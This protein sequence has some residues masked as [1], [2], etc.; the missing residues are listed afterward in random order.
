MIAAIQPAPVFIGMKRH[1]RLHKLFAVLTSILMLVQPIIPIFPLITPQIFAQEVTPTPEPTTNPDPTPTEEQA[2]PTPTEEASPTP[3]EEISPTP[4]EEITPTPTLEIMPSVTPEASPSPEPT[5]EVTPTPSEQTNPPQQQNGEPPHETSP[6]QEQGQ[7]LDGASTEAT[8]T[9]TVTVEEPVEEGEL[10]AVVLENVEADSLNLDSVDP[11]NSATLT[12]DKADY[13]PTDTA[14]IS[15]TGFKANHT[16]NLTVKSDDAPIT[17]TTVEITTDENGSFVYAYQL[18]GIYRPNYQ[19]AVTNPGGHIIATTTFTD[20]N[21][22]ADLDQYANDD[23]DWVNGNLG[24][25]NSTYYE[26]DTVPYRMKFDNLSLASHTI[27]IEWDTAKSDKH[28]TDYLESYDATESPDPCDGVSGC[29]GPGTTFPIPKDPQ[30]DNG[31]GS[32]ITQ[33]AGNFTLFGGT[34][35]GVSAY[36][37]P[38]GAGF[39]EDKSAQITITFTATQANPVLSWGGHISDRA[40]WGTGNSAVAIP[41][42]PYHMRNEG[43]DGG[44]GNQDRSLSADAVIFP[45]SITIIKQATPEGSTSFSFT[46]SPSPLSNFSLVDDGTSANTQLFSN[47]VNFQDYTVTETVPGAWTL[48]TIECSVTSA[49]GGS[50][51]VTN[52]SV[53]I[54][55]KEGENVNCTFTNEQQA[56]HLIVIKHVINDDGGS[57]AASDFTMTINGVTATGGNSF[58]GE[59]SPGTDKVVTP[60]SYNI[61]ETGPTGYSAG[62]STDCTGTI[63]AGQT[64]TCTVTND[65][66]QAYITVT[67]VVTNDDG[68]SAAPDD[69]DLTLEGTPVISGIAVAVN[70]GTYTAGE[71]LLPGYIFE[72]FS[73]DCD[74]NEDVTVALGESKSCTLTNNDQQAYII[75]DKTVINDNGGSAVANDFLL[76]VDGTPVSD[77]VAYP[78]DPGAHTAGETPLPGYTAGA[79]GGDCDL[80]AGVTVAL[81]Q[82]KTCTITNDDVAPTVTLT[83]VVIK[84]NGGTA[85]VNDFG[86]TVGGSPVSSGQTVSVNANT[87]IA[88]NEVGLSGYTFV[89]LTGDNACPS[90]LGGTVTLTEGQNVSCTITN[91]DNAPSLTLVKQVTN[92]DGG[93]VLASAWT[94]TATGPTTFSGAG[95]SVSNGASFDAGTYD[96]S[97]LGAAGYTASAWVCTGTGTQNDS[98][99]ITIG[100][101]QS[102]TC[103]ITNNDNGPTLKLIKAVRTSDGGGAVADDWTLSATAANPNDARNFSNLG[104]SGNFQPVFANVG[105][106]LSESLVSGY[107]ADSWSCTGGGSLVNNTVT[108]GLDEDVTCTITNDDIAPTLKLVK[109]VNAQDGGNEDADDWTLSATAVNPNDARNFS[110]LGG[111]GV[112]ETVFANVGY[113]LS[114]SLVPGYVAGNWSCDGGTLVASTVTL[115]LDE[116]VTCTIVNNDIAPTLTLTKVVVNDNGGGAFPDDFDLTVGGSPVLSGVT[117]SYPANQALAINETLVPGYSFVGITGNAK[118]PSVLGGTVTLDE[119]ENI[120]CTITNDD[121]PATLRVVKHVINDNGGQLNAGNFTITVTGTDVSNPSFSGDEG[122]TSVTLDAGA[123]SVTEGELFGY[124]ASYSTGCSGTVANGESKTCTITNNDIAPTLTLVKSVVNEDGGNNVANDFTGRINGNVVPWGVAQTL[125]A[126]SYTASEDSPLPGYTPSGWSGH[127]AT[128]GSVTLLP[129]DNKTCTIVNDDV[130]PTLTVIKHVLNN[131]GGDAT[132]TDFDIELNNNDLSFGSGSTLGDTTSYTS[133]P[134]VLAN[135]SYTLSEI[136]FTGYTEGTWSCMDNDTQQSVSHPFTLSEGQNVTCEITN[137]DVAPTVTLIKKVVGGLA[138]ASDFYLY[139]GGNL[140]TSGV[141]NAVLANTPYSVDEDWASGYSFTSLTGDTKCP[142]VLGGT[143]TLDEDEDITCTITNTRDTGDL[144]VHKLVDIN[145]D[146]QYDTETENDDEANG[147]GF[148]WGFAD[149]DTPFSMGHTEVDLETNGYDVYENDGSVPDYHFTGWY[150][151]DGEGSCESPDGDSLPAEINV[152]KGLTT[153]ITFCNARDTG[154]IT[155]DKVTNPSEADQEF[156][157]RLSQGETT[158]YD[159]L[160]QDTD[161]AETQEFPTGTYNLDELLEGINDWDLTNVSCNINEDEPFTYTGGDLLELGY[162][163]NIMCTFENKQRGTVIVT[164]YNDENGNGTQDKGEDVLSGWTM[165][166]TSEGTEQETTDESGEAIFEN[167]LPGTYALSEELQDGW[168]QTELTCEEGDTFTLDPGETQRCVVGNHQLNPILTISKSNDAAGDKNPGDSV[169]FT[170]VVTATQSAAFNVRVTDLPAGGFTYR[171]G[172]WTATKNGVPFSVSEPAYAS[173]GIWSIGDMSVSDVVTLTYVADISSDQKPGLYKDLAWAS[174]CRIDTDCEASDVNWVQSDAVNPGFV[175]DN[176]VGTQVNI[177]KDQQSGATLHP[178]TGEVLGAMTEL[179]ATGADELWLKLAAIFFLLGLGFVAAGRYARRLY[180]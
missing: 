175:D 71:T 47:I 68:G 9:P 74:G 157:I 116:D 78:V 3:T 144:I 156:T 8:P 129:G 106:V 172:S 126:G 60:G 85:D 73:G 72:G 79:W 58:A 48:N 15:G 45:S 30:V 138:I 121:Q 119:G 64:K 134:T 103:T 136:D 22:S 110:N 11:S 81:G 174:G 27:T 173:P 82:T 43:L 62:Y 104:G 147:L 36:S 17:S 141:A 83:K 111:S 90:V 149:D 70:P 25:H 114:E 120:S 63:A 29:S 148:S 142:A 125:T 158:I 128:N 44:G 166:L 164:K 80:N 46:A 86:L 122:G 2:A 77:G 163:D 49:N 124:A 10:Q 5:D 18:D 171:S 4:T 19:V 28:A 69:F 7:I 160:L 26:G 89:S 137:D 75:V 53:D 52:P 154:T 35:T 94:L 140:V 101:G 59:E 87:P 16:Y 115:G 165:N 180:V 84:D 170:I 127:C 123:Y 96:L 92:N 21:P 146:G 178:T 12:T 169:I 51:T 31:S 176:F 97:E 155:V 37:Y 112:F 39:T 151:T 41:G 23:N 66:Q 61:T 32:P 88:L 24:T 20:A 91:D 117:N 56:A 108:L 6:P 159:Y 67:K 113:V 14:I 161:P 162:G 13:A 100:L 177:V 152:N 54:D 118:C 33:N 76:T 153:D 109:T 145:A 95:P 99:T 133:T 143:V 42:S 34:I 105:Y 179:P 168:E 150:F 57:S 167:M 135:T 131:D 130:A 40:D 132:V 50:Q 102:A 139:L 107:E 55:L 93:T 1:T 65:D 98:D 38:D